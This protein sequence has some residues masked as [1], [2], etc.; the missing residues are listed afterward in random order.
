MVVHSALFL[1]S[2]SHGAALGIRKV[3]HEASELFRVSLR[4]RQDLQSVSVIWAPRCH[5]PKRAREGRQSSNCLPC[6]TGHSHVSHLEE[7]VLSFKHGA[8]LLP[9]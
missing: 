4:A 2:F 6:H 3:I 8:A 5:M 1:L 9:V 7:Q